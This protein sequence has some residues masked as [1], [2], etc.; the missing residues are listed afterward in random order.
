MARTPLRTHDLSSIF[1][2][3]GNN[4]IT[5]WGESDA[6]KIT[7]NADVKTMLVGAGGHVVASRSNDNHYT[8]ELTVLRNSADYALLQ[9]E[10][11]AQD[12]PSGGAIP[13]LPFLFRDTISGEEVSTDFAVF[14][15]APE[16]PTGK[17]ASEV[18][19]KLF[20]V[21]PDHILPE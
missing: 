17:E 12:P 2:V 15:A 19:F 9:A 20:L 11:L 13:R 6:V 21:S 4:H 8:A 10:R 5:A 16:L 14:T 1:V 3:L 18:T 7:P